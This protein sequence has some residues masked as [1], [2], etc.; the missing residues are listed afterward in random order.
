MAYLHCAAVPRFSCRIKGGKDFMDTPIVSI[1]KMLTHI[2]GRIGGRIRLHVYRSFKDRLFRRIFEEDREALLQIY[3]ALHDTNYSNSEELEIVTLD[4]VIYLC[5]KNDLAFVLAGTM[6]MYEQQSTDNPNMPLRFLLYL[7][8]EYEKLVERRRE[9]IYGSRLILL[10]VPQCV[11]FYNGD[12]ELPDEKILQLSEAFENK[13]TRTDVQVT[14]HVKNI[15]FGHNSELLN[16]CHKLYEYSYLINQVK[17]NIRKGHDRNNAVDMAVKHCIEAGIMEDFLRENR[18]EVSGML[19]A[20]CDMKF[21][22]EG[23]KKESYEDGYEGGI[24][25]G[26]KYIVEIMQ[27]SGMSREVTEWKLKEKCSLTEEQA[28]EKMEQYWKRK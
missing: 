27:E 15:N 6:N 3:N 16:K 25:Q 22:M 18:A 14:V 20:E 28:K 5:M 4:N 13:N 19:L 1:S 8:K 24:D 23:I 26:I 2:P 11:V 21:V 12:K 9:N 7:A 10:P 17:E